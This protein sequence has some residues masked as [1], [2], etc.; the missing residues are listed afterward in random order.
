M[1]WSVDSLFY[2][3]RITV[4]AT[5]GP[6]T[7]VREVPRAYIKRSKMPSSQRHLGDIFAARA[8]LSP[9]PAKI[10]VDRALIAGCK[11]ACAAYLCVNCGG[12]W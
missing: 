6:L 3:S 2:R 8:S 12:L 7:A 4:Q 9:T 5:R 1:T 11:M 10:S